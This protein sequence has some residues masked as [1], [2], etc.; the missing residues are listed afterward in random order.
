[1]CSY[2]CPRRDIDLI[3]FVSIQTDRLTV[4][5][6]KVSIGL[7][8][9]QIRTDHLLARQLYLLLFTRSH[10]I[11]RIQGSI[12][13]S[14]R[15]FVI[16]DI[17]DTRIFKSCQR[18]L[19]EPG[20]AGLAKSGSDL[21]DELVDDHLVVGVD[22]LV[23]VVQIVDTFFA[24]V[25]GTCFEQCCLLS[26]SYGITIKTPGEKIAMVFLFE[27][28]KVCILANFELAQWHG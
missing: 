28:D 20:N 25:F 21:P 4:K 26:V 24:V 23:E 7:V 10:T 17:V 27:I 9:D 18:R 16:H 5:E 8:D 1:M 12:P 19:T 11:E 2:E 3:L 14:A 13:E 22:L 15:Q 6:G